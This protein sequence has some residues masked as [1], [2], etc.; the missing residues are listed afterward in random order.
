[1]QVLVKEDNLLLYNFCDYLLQFALL[2]TC[3]PSA[4]A[5]A[6]TKNTCGTLQPLFFLC[7]VNVAWLNQRMA[8]R[9]VICIRQVLEISGNHYSMKEQKV[10]AALH[11]NQVL[12]GP[13]PAGC[14]VTHAV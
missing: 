2:R 14:L 4:S 9:K 12:R 3:L 8:Y 6:P 10:R 5:V 7:Q 11:A 13:P 1:M